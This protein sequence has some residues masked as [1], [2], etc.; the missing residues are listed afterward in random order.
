M[1]ATARKPL[2]QI[3]EASLRVANASALGLDA[4]Q[5][6]LGEEEAG[7]PVDRRVTCAIPHALLAT[8]AVD[9]SQ[10]AA[11]EKALRPTRSS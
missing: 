11:L 6:G 3:P 10:L 4:R 9:N 7:Y 1:S 8:H 2:L 5:E